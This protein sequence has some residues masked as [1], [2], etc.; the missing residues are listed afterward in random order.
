[1][2]LSVGESVAIAVSIV[3]GNCAGF[4]FQGDSDCADGFQHFQEC[5]GQE[6]GGGID[7]IENLC[8]EGTIT[9][10][11]E[12]FGEASCEEIRSLFGGSGL[13]PSEALNECIS[14]CT[15]VSPT[16]DEPDDCPDCDQE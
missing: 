9:C 1:M 8:E 12:C 10:Q 14:R 7:N 11:F 4:V 6:V 5:T 15:G 13:P 3:L 16:P 2:A